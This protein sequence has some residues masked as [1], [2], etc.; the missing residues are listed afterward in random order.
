MDTLPITIRKSWFGYVLIVV[1][2]LLLISAI[3]LA[4]YQT[5]INRQPQFFYLLGSFAILVFIAGSLQLYI[6][7]LSTITITSTGVTVINWQSLLVSQTSELNWT[8]VQDASVKQ[9]GFG[10]IF[11]YGTLLIQTAGT[12]KN[13]SFTFTP[14]PEHW[15]TFI[16][17]KDAATPVL[18]HNV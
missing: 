17:N 4:M 12:D 7:R 15:V 13:F 6:Y 1:F 11:N 3:I 5:V 18:T 16:E 9:N 8:R 14:N 10:T 2:S